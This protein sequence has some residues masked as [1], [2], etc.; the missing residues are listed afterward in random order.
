MF[1]QEAM[2]AT[3]EWASAQIAAK[4]N[5]C[6]LHKTPT[7][8]LLWPDLRWCC[9]KCADVMHRA[10]ITGSGKAVFDMTKPET[11]PQ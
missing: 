4:L 8:L 7:M 3:D 2:D 1:P 5:V 11:P 10:G 9:E 6:E